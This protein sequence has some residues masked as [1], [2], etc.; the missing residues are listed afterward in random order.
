MPEGDGA[1]SLEQ[2]VKTYM[3]NGGEERLGVLSSPMTVPAIKLMGTVERFSHVQ[4]TAFRRKV[5]PEETEQFSALTLRL[6]DGR[7]YVSFRGTDDSIIGWKENCLLA[8]RDSVPA[9]IDAL[10]Y[11]LEM[12]GRCG[13]PLLVGGHSKGGNL[14]V[15]AAA[16]APKTVQSRIQMV[17]NF[18]GP[19]FRKEFPETEGYRSIRWKLRTIMSQHAMV[20]TLLTQETDCIIVKSSASGMVAHDGFTWETTPQGF[21]L[22]R[23]FAPASRAFDHSMETILSDMDQRERIEFVEEFFG[24]LTSTG[25]QTLTELTGQNIRRSLAMVRQLSRAPEVQGML[26]ALLENMAKNYVSQRKKG[27]RRNRKPDGGSAA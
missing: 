26:A 15:Y 16:C 7:H 9:Q 25:A 22:C 17:Y 19:G 13:G 8:I 21:V 12:A 14:S 3:E 5:R 1:V 11:L 20:G 2:A 27:E 24:T 10:A 6:A 18:D 4:L 23:G